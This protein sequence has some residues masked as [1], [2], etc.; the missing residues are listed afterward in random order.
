MIAQLQNGPYGVAARKVKG[1][2]EW[3]IGS[4]T[5][6]LTDILIERAHGSGAVERPNPFRITVTDENAALIRGILAWLAA[7]ALT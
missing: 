6:R 2:N 3:R 7:A 1:T 5:L 4:H